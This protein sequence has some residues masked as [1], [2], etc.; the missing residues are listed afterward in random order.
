MKNRPHRYDINRS[1]SRHGDNYIKC[2][3]CLS[4]RWLH[5]LSNT[6]ATF[7]AQFMKS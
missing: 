6:E 4:K 3:M 5:V 2:K 7:E 1:R